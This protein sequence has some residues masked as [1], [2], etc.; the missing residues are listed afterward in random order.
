M[1]ELI[2]AGRLEVRSLH[3]QGQAEAHRTP[4]HGVGSCR[5]EMAEKAQLH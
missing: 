3:R 4:L 5:E 1:R 2:P